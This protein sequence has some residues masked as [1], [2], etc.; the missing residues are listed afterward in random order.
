MTG[1]ALFPWTFTIG[2]LAV[3]FGIWIAR[4]GRY[5][6]A[7]RYGWLATLVGVAHIPHFRER[8]PAPVWV[9]LSL[10]S[11]S[12]LGVLYPALSFAIQASASDADLSFAA[13]LFTFFRSFGLMLGVAIGGVAFQNSLRHKLSEFTELAPF[14]EEYS[15]DASVLVQIIKAMPAKAITFKEDRLIHYGL[16]YS[17]SIFISSLFLLV[18]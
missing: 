10:L 14:A 18:L 5:G 4:K 9:T 17:G 16:Y 12:G 13:G 3:I 8:T 1:V 15:K 7:V 2:P 11:G 6:W